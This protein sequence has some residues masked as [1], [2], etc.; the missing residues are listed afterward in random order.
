MAFL[1]HL[2]KVQEELLH[3]PQVGGDGSIWNDSQN[4]LRQSF[5]CDGQ[6]A[7]RLAILSRDRSC[8]ETTERANIKENIHK[9]RFKNRPDS[10]RARGK[11]WMPSH[12]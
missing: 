7:D 11:H 3:Y 6:G 2:N 5:L 12:Q 10:G 4:V 8:C 1:A 9:S